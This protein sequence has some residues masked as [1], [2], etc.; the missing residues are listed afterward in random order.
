MAHFEKNMF[1]NELKRRKSSE[2]V[3]DNCLRNHRNCSPPSELS[4]EF[5][6]SGKR[7]IGQLHNPGANI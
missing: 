3:K 1:T 7:Y 5:G 2:I 4:T 6:M